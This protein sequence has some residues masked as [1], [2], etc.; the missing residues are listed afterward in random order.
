MR[1]EPLE[2][3]HDDRD[4]L[5]VLKPSGIA[6]TAPGGS[7]SLTARLE[8]RIGRSLHPTSR[9]DLEVTGE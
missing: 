3:V 7:D 1:A 6:T 5:V 9:L 8:R 4:L 2:I